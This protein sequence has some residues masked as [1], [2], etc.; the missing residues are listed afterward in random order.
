MPGTAH[1]GRE[2]TCSPY[3]AP[4]VSYIRPTDIETDRETDR[5][6]QTERERERQ[7]DRDLLSC[8]VQQ[9]PDGN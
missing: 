9:T 6:R 5:Q 4:N 1:P 2:L 7:T 8:P 3:R